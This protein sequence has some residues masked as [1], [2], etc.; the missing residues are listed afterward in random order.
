MTDWQLQ[1]VEQNKGLLEAKG[2]LEVNIELTFKL[3]VLKNK[4]DRNH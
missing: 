2:K 1:K 3:S 4:H